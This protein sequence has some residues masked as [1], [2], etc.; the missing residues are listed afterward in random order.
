[1]MSA[2][3]IHSVLLVTAVAR[4]A[5]A[6]ESPR[7]L[8]TESGASQVTGDASVGGAKGTLAFTGGTS[9]ESVEGDKSIF[10]PLSRCNHH[11]RP[12]QS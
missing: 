11:G 3:L 10:T 2:K 6:S 8:I 12:G 5:G 7:V 9:P 4:L 1:M